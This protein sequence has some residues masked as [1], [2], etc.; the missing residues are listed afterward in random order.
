M[1]S[2][3]NCLILI[4]LISWSLSSQALS[5]TGTEGWEVEDLKS[6]PELSNFMGQ[7]EMVISKK[8]ADGES[9]FASAFV[10]R[11]KLKNSAPLGDNASAWRE[12]IFGPSSKGMIL[13]K[14]PQLAKR[15]SVW[16]YTVET[17]S[18]SV[19]GVQIYSAHFAVQK[20]DEI[21]LLTYQQTREHYSKYLKDVL[22]LFAKLQVDAQKD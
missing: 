2:V 1:F 14:P 6:R 11:I 21:I 7:A 17:Q 12:A 19:A 9:S 15:D 13:I 5:F 3:K 18:D 16:H 10:Y 22:G 4:S 8:V 20:G